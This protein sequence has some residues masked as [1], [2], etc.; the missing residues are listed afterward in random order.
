MEETWHSHY[1]LLPESDHIFLREVGGGRRPLEYARLKSFIAEDLNLHEFGIGQGD[2]L[3]VIIPNGPEAAVCFLGMSLQCTYAPLSTK[4]T[5]PALQFEFEDLPA[6]AVVVLAGLPDDHNI[7]TVAALCGNL[8]IIELCPS[9]DD[10]G[11]FSLRWRKDSRQLPHLSAGRVWPKREDIALVL[12]TS[13]TTNKPKVVPLTH[14][15]I[16]TGGLCISST[17]GLSCEDVCIN[18]MP[19]FHIHGISVNVL[20]TALLS[21][22]SVYATKGFTDGEN[23]FHGLR[24]SPPPTWYSAVPTMH[25]EILNF[26]EEYQSQNDGVAPKHHLQFARNCSAAL[27][28]SVGER[29]ERVLGIQVVCTYA[30]DRVYAYRQQPKARRGAQ[31]S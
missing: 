25:Q 4:L 9:V 29:M 28:P 8:P 16:T 14:G 10:V 17:L 19:L 22:S 24:L 18:I 31:T 2:R 21:G 5:P 27:L 30:Y 6:K 26:A 3:C 20:V 1:D 15:N 11:L 7:L 12:H 13:G 23:F